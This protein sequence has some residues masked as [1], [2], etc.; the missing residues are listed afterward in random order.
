MEFNTDRS[1]LIQQYAKDSNYNT[2]RTFGIPWRSDKLI[3]FPVYRIPTEH[4]SFNF[5]NARIRAEKSSREIQLHRQLDPNKKEDQKVVQDILLNSVWFDK[6]D[7]QQL[8]T[9]LRIQQQE[10]AIITFDGVVIDGNRRLACLR[11][12]HDK[13]GKPQYEVIDACIL[14]KASKKELIMLENRLQLSKS[15]KVEYGPVND[16]L[17]LRE[18]KEEL[19]FSMPEILHS[20]NYRWTEDDIELMIQEMNLI[21]SYLDAIGRSKDY[22]IIHRKGVESFR[23]LLQGLNASLGRVP[24]PKQ[25]TELHRRKLIG[26]QLINH[27]ETTYAD[28]R[29]LRDVYKNPQACQ[30]FLMNCELYKNPNASNAFS[31]E[32]QTEVLANLHEAYQYIG[33]QRTD[34]VKLAASALDKLKHIDLERIPKR[35]SEFARI[36]S[37][38][39]NRLSL[40]N[41]KLAG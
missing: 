1:K 13:E 17:R 31:I 33:A 11:T 15:Y 34:P 32:K 26:F 8:L 4:L 41:K 37:E 9:S 12:L 7:T 38:I 2:G 25:K 6:S 39:G 18:M 40:I 30:E 21:D 19:G 36:V 22:E 29:E 3:D 27:P 24:T 35:N 14:P 23:A 5:D 20:V 16:R 10:P 28:I